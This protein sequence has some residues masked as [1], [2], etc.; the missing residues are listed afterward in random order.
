MASSS[1]KMAHGGLTGQD[2]HKKNTWIPEGYVRVTGPDGDNY[3]VPEFM[4]PALHQTCESY[5]KKRDL[6]AFNAAGSV[7]NF[8][9]PSY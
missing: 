4:V 7:S 2:S 8:Y 3:V 1:K 6:D 5:K 9:F